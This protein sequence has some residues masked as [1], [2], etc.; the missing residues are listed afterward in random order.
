MLQWPG[1]GQSHPG[2]REESNYLRRRGSHWVRPFG[3]IREGGDLGENWAV[4]ECKFGR[5]I[6]Q[7]K[8]SP[9]CVTLSELFALSETGSLLT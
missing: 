8:S 9:S 7:K 4:V 3:E 1:Q 6:D 2:T 5:D